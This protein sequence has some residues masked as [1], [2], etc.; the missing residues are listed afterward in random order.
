[1]PKPTKTPKKLDIFVEAAPLIEERMSGIGHATLELVRALEKHPGHGKRF[2]IILLVN[3]DKFDKLERWKFNTVQYKKIPFPLRPFNLLWKY[4]LLPPIDLFA[5]RGVYV[6]PNYKNLWLARSKSI[7]YVHD[8]SFV[9][10]PEFVSPKNQRFL[11]KNMPRWLRRTTLVAADSQSAKNEIIDYYHISRDKIKTL[12]HGVDTSIYY[13]RDKNEIESVKKKYGI[14]KE[15]I[16]YLGNIEPRKNIER[17]IEAYKGLPAMLQDKYA[18][19]LVGGGGWL[20]ESI[21]ESIKSAQK[22][23][24]NIIKPEEFVIDEDLPALHSGATMLFHPALYEGFGLSIVQA[25]ACGKAVLAGDN[26]SMP[27]IVGDAG[28]LVDAKNVTA[29]MTALQ[30][31]LDNEQE[32]AKLEAKAL[33]QARKFSWITTANQLVEI[34]Q[35]IS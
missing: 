21:V 35:S 29:I 1:M 13:P 22:A 19:V 3:A 12:Y 2:Q 26:S 10:Y 33:T 20:N 11:A 25:M 4:R 17:M 30:G 15:Y 7:T 9:L 5:G 18:L 14:T 32:R 28:V 6:F 8:I 24:F 31:L 34:A 27:E 16:F 23:G